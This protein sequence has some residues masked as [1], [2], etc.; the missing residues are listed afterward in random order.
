MSSPLNTLCLF[1]GRPSALTPFLSPAPPAGTHTACPAAPH[2]LSHPGREEA[3]KAV[4]TQLLM[5]GDDFRGRPALP[6]QGA[7]FQKCVLGKNN[8]FIQL[9]ECLIM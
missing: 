1:W 7:T 6:L 8:P 9:T 2:G 4:R 5:G 3:G